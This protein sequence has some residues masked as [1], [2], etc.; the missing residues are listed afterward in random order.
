MTCH[1]LLKSAISVI[2][3]CKFP[4]PLLHT[5]GSKIDIFNR[6]NE[7][8]FHEDF[9]FHTLSGAFSCL[10][11]QKPFRFYFSGNSILI[12]FKNFSNIWLWKSRNLFCLSKQ[13]FFQIQKHHGVSRN[14]DWLGQNDVCLRWKR[15]LHKVS[16]I[17]GASSRAVTEKVNKNREKKVKLCSLTAWK[18]T[19]KFVLNNSQSH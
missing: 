4:W 8:F 11:P 16:E 12:S 14:R 17:G 1:F 3:H 18:I 7:R 13:T 6:W 15:P 9:K 19:E 2:L 5:Q 10:L